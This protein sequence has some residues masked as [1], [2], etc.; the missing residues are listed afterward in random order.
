M[1]LPYKG[2]IA[3]SF[4]RL[5]DQKNMEYIGEECGLHISIIHDNQDQNTFLLNQNKIFYL[6][7]FLLFLPENYEQQRCMWQKFYQ[8]FGADYEKMIDISRNVYLIKNMI[9]IIST[10]RP[11]HSK[12]RILDYGSGSGLTS[13]VNCRGTLIGYEPVSIMRKQAIKRGY[14]TLDYKEFISLPDH[15]FDAGFANYVF[16]MAIDEKSIREIVGKLKED[17]VFVANFYKDINIEKVNGYF[18]NFGYSFRKIPHIKK[19]F[20]SFYVYRKQ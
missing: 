2:M 9:E 18:G 3:V 17:A 5:Q 1:K 10:E 8:V 14:D 19:E 6:D 13:Y 20:G 11:L 7:R 15:Y 16:H 12:S 4:E